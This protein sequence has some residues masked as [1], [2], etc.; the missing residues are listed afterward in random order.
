MVLLH[1]TVN[2]MEF[3]AILL[4]QNANLDQ[5][6]HVVSDTALDINFTLA[7]I[8]KSVACVKVGVAPHNTS[9]LVPVDAVQFLLPLN[10]I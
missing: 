8:V 5:N 9:A 1:L 4:I 2:L 10:C 3:P 7:L 6:I